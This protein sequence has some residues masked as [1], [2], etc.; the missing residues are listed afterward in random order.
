MPEQINPRES[1]P[2]LDL[3]TP[4]GVARLHQYFDKYGW[5]ILPGAW[6]AKQA[7]ERLFASTPATIK[8]QK[9]AA[10]AIIK[11]GKDAGV[12]SMTVTVDERVGLELAA[13]IEGLPLKIQAG[14]CGK[15]TIEVKY[16]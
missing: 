1:N 13:P 16:K 4:D 7:I 10:V 2:N 11:A 5:M 8:E 12:D 14:S 3:T 6:V 15:I 9:D